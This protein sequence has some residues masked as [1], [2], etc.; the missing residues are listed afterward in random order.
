MPHHAQDDLPLS[1]VLSHDLFP[2]RR[3][4][5]IQEVA[6]AWAVDEQH[7]RNL[8]E[9]GDL[10]AIDFRTNAPAKPS[11]IASEDSGKANR[12]HRSVRQWLRIPV[13][14]YDDFLKKRTV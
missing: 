3:V 13:S 9:C 10:R 6:K 12:K 7:V 5:T 14:A 4:L 8:I 1:S 11:D 2:G